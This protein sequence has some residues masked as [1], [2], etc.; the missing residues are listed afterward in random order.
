[1]RVAMAAI[2]RGVINVATYPIRSTWR[3]IRG[4]ANGVPV[5]RRAISRDHIMN[6]VIKP[7][8]SPFVALYHQDRSKLHAPPALPKG[9]HH[10]HDYDDNRYCKPSRIVQVILHR[11]RWVNMIVLVFSFVATCVM[12]ARY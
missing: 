2:G 6:N 9:S 3:D 11:C 7:A 1:L 10:I 12:V 5:A 4:F 8:V